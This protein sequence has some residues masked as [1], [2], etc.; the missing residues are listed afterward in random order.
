MSSSREWEMSFF[1][2]RGRKRRSGNSMSVINSIKNMPNFFDASAAGAD[3][4]SIIAKA[5]T[6][7]SPTVAT[8]VSHGCKIFRIWVEI[9]ISA[10]ATATEGVTTG[11][12]AY[13]IK[14]PGNNL[15][16]PSPGSVGTSNE[17]KFVFKTWKGLIA[18]RKE[19]FPPYT[20]RG[21]VKIP[22]V[23][24]RMGTDDVLYFVFKPTGVQAIACINFIYKWFR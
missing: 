11:V 22:K 16:N 17:K 18:S 8:D 5:V 6:S 19:G 15:T 23:Y 10:S 21:W 7:P 14:N 2:R 1:Q 20:W 3:A 4:S 9:W 24:Q 13:I 12:D